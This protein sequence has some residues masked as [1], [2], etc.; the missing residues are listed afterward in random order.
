MLKREVVSYLDEVR[1]VSAYDLGKDSCWYVW[2][3]K[4]DV[5]GMESL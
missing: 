5:W 4:A 3:D 2:K 1:R